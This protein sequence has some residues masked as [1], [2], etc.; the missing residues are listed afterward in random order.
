MLL[1]PIA[2]Y[3]LFLILSASRSRSPFGG[4]MSA[5]KE[6]NFACRIN[7]IATL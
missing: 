4:A 6:P 3:R 2:L 5:K 7:V 1:R